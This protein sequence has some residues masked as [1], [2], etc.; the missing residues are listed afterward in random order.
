MEMPTVL[1][2]LSYKLPA[3][4]LL[5]EGARYNPFDR[6]TRPGLGDPRRRR[7]VTSCKSSSIISTILLPAKVILCFCS[8]N[9]L[10]MRELSPLLNLLDQASL[11]KVGGLLSF[12][13]HP[14]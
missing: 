9:C 4:G 2:F 7:P 6:L 8:L 11:R 10:L 1:P 14:T 5:R 13:P 12:R 3:V